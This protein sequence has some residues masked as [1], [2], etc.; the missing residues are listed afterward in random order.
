MQ[1]SDRHIGIFQRRVGKFVPFRLDSLS[2]N[3]F[4]ENSHFNLLNLATKHLSK[5]FVMSLRN[6]T[7]PVA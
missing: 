1:L 4:G 6:V 2:C 3:I 5:S 7:V